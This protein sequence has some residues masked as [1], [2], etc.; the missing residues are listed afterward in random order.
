MAAVPLPAVRFQIARPRLVDSV[1]VA[2]TGTRAIS[3][4]EF[5]DSFW[6]VSV[7]TAALSAADIVAVRAWATD[8]VRKAQQSVIYVPNDFCLPRAYWGNADAPA[9]NDTGTLTSVTNGFA[10]VI[11]SVTNGLSLQPGDRLSL[12]TG[13]YRSL[14]EVAVG[15]V[16]T[17]GSISLTLSNPVPSYIAPGAVARFRQ[18]ELNMRVLPGSFDMP[19]EFRPVASFTL[20][21]VPK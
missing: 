11:G 20:I 2:R 4:F 10:V 12:K 1:S 16:A 5:A 18:P 13:D 21:E 6:Q 14:H 8:A 15:A 3:A 7:R 19:D 17:G 9:V